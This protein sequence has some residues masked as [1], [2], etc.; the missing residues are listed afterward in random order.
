LQGWFDFYQAVFDRFD[1]DLLLT[2]MVDS[3]AAM[4]PYELVQSYGSTALWWKGTR[5]RNRH[6]VL[7]NTPYDDL[8]AVH[9][10]YRAFCSG[11]QSVEDFPKV[12][13]AA[14]DYRRELGKSG[15]KPGYFERRAKTFES[16]LRMAQRSIERA[17]T[18]GGHFGPNSL[19]KSASDAVRRAYVATRYIE[20]LRPR[21]QF[22]YF[23]LHAQPEPSTGVLAPMHLNQAALVEQVSR[24][25]PMTHKLYVKEH[26]RM[27]RDNPR[28]VRTYRQITSLPN[29]RL[30]EVGT[31]SHS[32]IADSDAVVT[33]TGTPAFEAVLSGKPAITCGE[34]H[35]NVLSGVSNCRTPSDLASVINAVL[36]DH[37]HDERDTLRYLTAIF[38]RSVELP[39]DVF[40]LDREEQRRS[41]ELLYPLVDR[42]L[43]Q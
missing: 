24:S 17:L 4:V 22:V 33:P 30:I 42:R 3:T 28:A 19:V 9:E 11:E 32:L 14:E 1:P 40:G 39:A 37:E 20:P 21:E 35:F 7:E 10:L 29:V 41:A 12:K 25:L 16:P 13:S 27:F 34:A 18:G 43:D 36:F 23:P 38:A 2:N 6:A 8:T 15:T 31:D 26:P 5:V